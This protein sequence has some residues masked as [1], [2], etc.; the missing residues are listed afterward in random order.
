MR[1]DQRSNRSRSGGWL[2]AAARPRGSTP[3]KHLALLR[4]PVLVRRQ[5]L[6]RHG[7]RSR[8]TSPEGDAGTAGGV[9]AQRCRGGR[10]RP[11]PLRGEPHGQRCVGNRSGSRRGDQAPVGGQGGGVPVANARWPAHLLHAHL[12]S[13]R[14]VPHAA[15]I[16]S[17]GDRYA[18]A[19]GGGAP[20]G[21]KRRVCFPRGGGGP[22]PVGDRGPTAA[23]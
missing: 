5:L 9:R 14:R 2:R 17:D 21:G 18:A 16:G 6:E 7:L 13:A 15:R 22:W 20:T 23:L 12:S 3:Q 19:N 11:F 8:R 10:G 4:W 1:G